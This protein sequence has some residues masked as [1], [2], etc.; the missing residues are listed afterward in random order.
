MKRELWLDYA[1]SAACILVAL[2]HLF[3]SFEESAIL[4]NGAASF[5]VELIYRFHVPV[6][7]FCGGYLFQKKFSKY[8]SR[9][10]RMKNRL[11]RCFDYLVVYVVFSAVTYY[12][13]FLL[14]GDVN[15]PVEQSFIQTLVSEPVNQMW[16]MYAIF[17]ITLITPVISSA[18]SCLTVLIIAVIFKLSVCIPVV[19]DFLPH[20]IE[21]VMNNEIWFLLGGVWAYKS[22]PPS[23]KAAYP[24]M[25]FFVIASAAVY[26][27]GIKS[28]FIDAHLTFSGMLGAIEIIRIATMKKQSMSLVSRIFSKY[29]LQIY[30]LH[31][32][33]AAGI[34]VVLLKL[35]IENFPIH[36]IAGLIFSFPVPVLCAF[37]AEKT[38]ILNMFFFPSKTI[39]SI[40]KSKQ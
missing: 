35:Q 25:L 18:V 38:K 22:I 26:F 10:G 27:A 20:Q 5:L 13:K 12:I 1:R 37:I 15:A 16:Y 34:R 36:L 2:G 11:L 24:L 28:A 9:S 7:F 31:T 23:K 17:F 30:L 39:L 32:I 29:I 4:V 8:E 19:S 14:S 40:R 33:C 21:Y 3:L 6:F